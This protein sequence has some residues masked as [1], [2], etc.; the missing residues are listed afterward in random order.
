MKF[1][2][3]SEG[4][5]RLLEISLL[6]MRSVSLPALQDGQISNQIDLQWDRDKGQ[7]WLGVK[8]AMEYRAWW[9]AICYGRHQHSEFGLWQVHQSYS[10]VSRMAF[11]YQESCSA[12]S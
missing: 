6:Q 3:S 1:G 4:S 12:M 11:I 7:S 9:C 10:E 5:L 2:Y 8:S